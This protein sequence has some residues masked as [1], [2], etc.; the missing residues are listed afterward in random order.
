MPAKTPIELSLG[1]T[2]NRRL[3]PAL[4][5]P[6]PSPLEKNGGR[7]SNC[8]VISAKRVIKRTRIHRNYAYCG[9]AANCLV[10]SRP[11]HEKRLNEPR[12]IELPGVIS[13]DHF[14]SIG[15]LARPSPGPIPRA[16]YVEWET[17]L[18][19]SHLMTANRFEIV[20]VASLM[21]LIIFAHDP[22]LVMTLLSSPRIWP[23]VLDAS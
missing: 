9:M 3:C 23:A 11:R 12:G 6:S 21:S 19:S 1:D 17:F 16:G 5:N 10:V 22:G 8:T 14:H 7:R 18:E 2:D 4:T 13:A 15:C 20:G